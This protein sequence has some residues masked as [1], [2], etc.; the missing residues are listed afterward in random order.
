M[1]SLRADRRKRQNDT[2]TKSLQAELQTL[3]TQ[4]GQPDRDGKGGGHSSKGEGTT[5]HFFRA[6]P[7]Q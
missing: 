7:Q 3:H 5:T 6:R 1:S 4:R 2:A